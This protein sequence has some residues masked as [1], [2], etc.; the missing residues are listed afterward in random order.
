MTF[1]NNKIHMKNIFLIFL[2][3]FL[4]NNSIF[5]Q[6][7]AEITPGS[8]IETKIYPFPESEGN[9]ANAPDYSPKPGDQGLHYNW[10]NSPAC[11]ISI[12][13]KDEIKQM[14][15]LV[16]VSCVNAN[17][18]YY[19]VILGSNEIQGYEFH[20]Y[21]NHEFQNPNGSHAAPEFKIINSSTDY[22]IDPSTGIVQK[23]NVQTQSYED[24]VVTFDFPGKSYNREGE[25][26][27]WN[28]LERISSCNDAQGYTVYP[29]DICSRITER[30]SV[31]HREN[32][33][34]G[35]DISIHIPDYQN[36]AIVTQIKIKY[37]SVYLRNPTTNSYL[38]EPGDYDITL[39]TSAAEA[40]EEE[41][42]VTGRT[43][44]CKHTVNYDAELPCYNKEGE[45]TKEKKVDE[46][47]LAYYVFTGPSYPG[48]TTVSTRAVFGDGTTET[49]SDGDP[50]SHRYNEEG[51]YT[52][53]LFVT[54]EYKD[55]VIECESSFDFDA[56]EVCCINFAPTEEK[57]YWLSAWVKEDRIQGDS[58]IDYKNGYIKLNFIGST[59]SSD[60]SFYASGE[61]IEGWQRIVGEFTVPNSINDIKIDL[62][63]K[64]AQVDI[65]FD[66]IRI[67]PFNASM[68][69]YVYD[70]VTLL[71]SAE[72]DDNNFATI[73]E[74]DQEGQLIRI[75]KETQRGIMTI[76]E[77]RSSNPKR[78]VSESVS[79]PGGNTG[80]VLDD[81][82][83][84]LE[85]IQHEENV[86][87]EG[88]QTSGMAELEASQLN[89]TQELL[90]L[91]KLEIEQLIVGQQQELELV[92]QEQE[93]AL[94]QEEHLVQLA[95]QEESQ[96]VQRQALE[97]QHQHQRFELE[98]LY[99]QQ[100]EA[101]SLQHQMELEQL[102]LAFYQQQQQQQQ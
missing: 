21:L 31:E 72:L 37:G 84:E 5:G 65:Y 16:P 87:L 59:G 34:S 19:K 73:Y 64:D 96:L 15:E 13:S 60:V 91:Q 93:L 8:T 18:F 23:R 58:Y 53:K 71:L 20:F 94:L 90:Q 102:I 78:N 68:K 98:Q 28:G 40:L 62:I 27:Y 24:Y 46:L 35:R 99:L 97:E 86:V 76:Q 77:S 79:D 69:S 81:L 49:F 45:I 75:K 100:L 7:E 10:R 43:F 63:N 2:T 50:I 26:V 9:Y 57:R 83:R 32:S 66:D 67:H 80:G 4:L 61:I 25:Y 11:D 12:D 29:V 1:K 85:E 70:P 74:Y 51:N 22:R 44:I 48:Y 89:E 36:E 30:M 101:L 88:A 3:L 42:T 92:Q 95:I 41:L 55:D 56:K 38:W 39:P 52:V 33:N 14:Y 6:C 82:E 17:S 54:L 47:G